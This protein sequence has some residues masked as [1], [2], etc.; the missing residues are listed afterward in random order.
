MDYNRAEREAIGICIAI[1]ALNDIANHVLLELR[2][3]NSVPGETEV[4]FHSQVHQ[5][6]FLIR[7]LDFAKEG[8]D[9]SLTGVAG[10]CLDV[11]EAACIS[12]SFDYTGSITALEISTKALRSWLSAEAA[13]PLWLPHL[14]SEASL[15]IP[16]VE[17][18]YVSGNQSKHN[19]SRLTG[20]AKRLAVILSD[21]GYLASAEQVTLA[22]DDFRE[23]LEGGF[24]VAYGT[25]LAELLNNVRWGLQDYL[26]P[27]YEL[28][29]KLDLT[30]QGR[31]Y[32]E[33]P[34]AIANEI[35][36]IWYWRLMNNVRSAP[37]LRR[38]VGAHY[39]KK[40]IL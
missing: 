28:S 15:K 32:Y 40:E 24:F 22:L 31:Y 4:Y 27:C 14:E 36:R 6:L 39:L 5:Q 17:L 1:E 30:G 10:S 35:P 26:F 9:S 12:K 2:D 7:L 11:L 21:H 38:F 23:H 3:V 29:H 33:Y 25:W 19:L 37:N 8:G 34:D 16:R 13:L 20:L 18:L